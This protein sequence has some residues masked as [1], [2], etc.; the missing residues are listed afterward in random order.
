MAYTFYE[1]GR[2]Q[3]TDSDSLTHREEEI[4]HFERMPSL[5]DLLEFMAGMS[6]KD[7]IYMTCNLLTIAGYSQT[8]IA[9]SLGVQPQTYRNRLR[10]IRA[11]FRTKGVRP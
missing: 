1:R 11:D 2:V 7:Q 5:I 4:V 9:L 10:E 6:L 8:E 3:L